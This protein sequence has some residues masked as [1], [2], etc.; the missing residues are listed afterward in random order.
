MPLRKS[1]KDLMKN[2]RDE[3]PAKIWRVNDNWGRWVID[4]WIKEKKKKDF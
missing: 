1:N 4:A 3:S 2:T